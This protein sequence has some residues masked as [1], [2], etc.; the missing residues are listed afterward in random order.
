ME[1]SFHKIYNITYMHMAFDGIRNLLNIVENA[2]S[3]LILLKPITIA[4][5]LMIVYFIFINYKWCVY[6]LEFPFS[7]GITW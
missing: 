2:V 1:S 4:I 6:E 5:K 3:L 7:Y